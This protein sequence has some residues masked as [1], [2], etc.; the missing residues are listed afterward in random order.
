MEFYRAIT[1]ATKQAGVKE[2]YRIY[3]HKLDDATKK[4]CPAFKGVNDKAKNGVQVFASMINKVKQRSSPNT[5]DPCRNPA[6][7]AEQRR[8]GAQCPIKNAIGVHNCGDNGS[9]SDVIIGVSKF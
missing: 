1:D 6:L 5:E 9:V 4:Q 2:G 8:V 7:C 3:R